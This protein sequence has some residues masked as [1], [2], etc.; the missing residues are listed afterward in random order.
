MSEDVNLDDLQ[1]EDVL[2][3]QC[4]KRMLFYLVINVV[5]PLDPNFGETP[6]L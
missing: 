6:P 5:H 1:Q 4:S 2:G 3:E